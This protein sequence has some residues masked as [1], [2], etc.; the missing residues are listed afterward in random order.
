MPHFCVIVLKGTLQLHSLFIYLAFS[1]DTLFFNNYFKLEGEAHFASVR[2]KKKKKSHVY[3]SLLN[4]YIS[5]MNNGS[6]IEIMHSHL[7]TQHLK[8]S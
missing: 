4:E 1:C 6:F 7:Y 3:Y 8:Y 5:D 2:D